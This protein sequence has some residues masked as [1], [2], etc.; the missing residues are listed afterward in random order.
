MPS[1]S[2]A[3][4]ALGQQ[5]HA[6]DAGVL[7]ARIQP[8]HVERRR[9][10]QDLVVAGGA[11]TANQH[12]DGFAA[13]A[14]HE[15]LPLLDAVVLG[16]LDLQHGRA[17]RRIHVQTAIGGIA[18]R[19]PRRFVRVQTNQAGLV[20][21]RNVWPDAAQLGAREIEH[22][23]RRPPATL[24]SVCEAFLHRPCMRVEALELGERRRNRADRAQPL[25]RQFLHRHRA[26]EIGHAEARNTA[27][28]SRTSAAR[29]S[30]RCSNRRRIPASTGRGTRSPPRCT[31]ASQSRGRSICRIRCSGA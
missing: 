27:A 7:D 24:G 22:A 30:C 29:D 15:D 25:D 14:R 23:H 16:Q 19:A 21:A 26:H 10:D 20:R 5:R 13:A 4:V 18:G 11:E 8:I 12:V 28:R 6:H 17:R 3:K 9:A 1:T 31:R 2:S